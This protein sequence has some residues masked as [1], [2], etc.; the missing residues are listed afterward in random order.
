MLSASVRAQL[1]YRASFFLESLGQFLV[2][3]IDFIGIWAL[4][5]RFGMIEG[6]R[7]EEVALLYGLVYV[8]F[9]LAEAS[10]T[11]FDSFS[12]IVSRGDFDRILA[13]PRSTILQL[14]GQQLSI[15]RTGKLLQGVVI[16][17]W[18]LLALPISFSF[19]QYALLMFALIGGYFLFYGLFIIQATF[20]FWTVQGIEVMNVLTYGGRETSQFPMSIYDKW[21]RRFF[22]MV[23]PVAGVS[24]YP[25]MTIL[26]KSELTV[27]SRFLYSASPMSGIL[28][29]FVACII[30]TFGVR[31]YRST[32]S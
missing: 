10:S 5:S 28:F 16:L 9:A 19:S 3:G 14:A 20:C 1:E 26:G 18:A 24:Y 2:T 15:R 25:V 7:F 27:L 8:S 32:G 23:V 31:R 29:F 12:E 30:W 6:W 21:L 13:R 22:T 17:I 11:G 4:F